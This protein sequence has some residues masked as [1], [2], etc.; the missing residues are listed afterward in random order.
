MSVDSI[1]NPKIFFQNLL[2]AIPKNWSR[3]FVC[4]PIFI[5]QDN[6]Q[7]HLIDDNSLLLEEGIRDEWKIQ[8]K[9][10]PPNILDFNVLDFVF[11]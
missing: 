7:S 4:F 10:Q 2:L 5:Q 8:L 6:H 11:F 1:N 9:S 3:R